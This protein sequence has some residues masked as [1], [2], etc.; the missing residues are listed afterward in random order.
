M[1]ISIVC[2]KSIS[3]VLL[4]ECLCYGTHGMLLYTS[5]YMCVC[6]EATMYS[7]PRKGWG[8][9]LMQGEKVGKFKQMI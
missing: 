2:C 9:R 4:W 7:S 1:E 3:K 8:E 5:V 6:L